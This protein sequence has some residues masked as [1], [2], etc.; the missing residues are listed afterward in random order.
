MADERKGPNLESLRE[1]T[2]ADTDEAALV[3]DEYK[4]RHDL[5]WR[6]LV[7]ST[8]A[9]VALVTVQYT[10]AFAASCW[11]IVFAFLAALIYWIVTF[12]AV[13]R[14][15]H[16]YHQLKTWHRFRQYRLLGLRFHDHDAFREPESS[17]VEQRWGRIYLVEGFPRRVGLYLALVL[18]G[19]LVMG[20]FSLFS[21]LN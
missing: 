11:L 3:W 21:L 1:M 12:V 13:D 20:S 17:F 15:L 18:I 19:I 10:D 16:L 6:H 7:R 5:I 4:Y 2:L 8:L 9:L 14:E